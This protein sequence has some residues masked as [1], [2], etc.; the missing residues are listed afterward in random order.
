M[1]F[2]RRAAGA[3]TRTRREGCGERMDVAY[4]AAE[5]GRRGEDVAAAFVCRKGWRI[6]ERNWHY[7]HLELDMVALDG[8]ELVFVEVKT[9][10]AG[11][12]GSPAASSGNL[13]PMVAKSIPANLFSRVAATVAA[14]IATSEP[15]M[16]LLTFPHRIMITT[17]HSDIIASAGS[18]LPMLLK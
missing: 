16:R 14:R 5:L 7:R 17:Q 18:M 10:T 12:I 3:G 13:D 2:G 11:G 15:G 9:R 8:L 6:L 4:P 1:I